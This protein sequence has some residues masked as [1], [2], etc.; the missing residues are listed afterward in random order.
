MELSIRL[1]RLAILHPGQHQ[2]AVTRGLQPHAYQ[3]GFVK[4]APRIQIHCMVPTG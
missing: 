2:Y 1:P 4:K 3:M